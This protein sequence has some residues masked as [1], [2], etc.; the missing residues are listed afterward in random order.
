MAMDFGAL[1]PEINSAR[2]YFGPGSGPMLAAAAAWDGVADELRST[3]STYRSVI[4]ELTDEGWLGPASASMAAAVAPYVTWMNVTGVQAEQTAANAAAAAGAF[5][6]AFASTV[7]PAAV[8][9]N[10]AQLMALVA[11]NVIGQ[12][13]PAIAATEAQ[14]GEMW[15]QDAAAM[16]GYAANSASA[17]TLKPFAQPVQTTKPAGQAS[18]AAAVAQTTGASAGAGTQDMLAQLMSS[19]PTALQGLASPISSASGSSTLAASPI[20]SGFTQL[21]NFLSGSDGS[22]LGTFLNSNLFNGLSSAG[23]VNPAIITPAATSAM[24]DINS[25]G[26]GASGLPTVTTPG[27]IGVPG[28]ASVTLPAHGPASMPGLGGVSA[29][30]A[31]A[32]LVGQLSVPQ[33]WTTATQVTNHSGAAFP[34]GGWTTAASAGSGAQGAVPAGMPGMPG[35]PM[36]GGGS[37]FGHGPRYGFRPTVMPR[38]PA[39][40]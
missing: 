37:G 22:P 26:S 38:P 12:N 25:V 2:M 33:A 1:P 17:S 11:T 8:A 14:Y 13:T 23:Y 18:Q 29:V 31:R 21:L 28:L 5:E 39:A 32:S 16:Y 36:G 34:G 27:G 9:A 7:P 15:A 35:V 40:G 6:A 19:L 4:S 10:R 24:S 3:A 30:T 20:G